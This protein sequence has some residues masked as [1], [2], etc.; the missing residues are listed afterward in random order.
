MR[1]S[2][3]CCNEHNSKPKYSQTRASFQREFYAGGC[4]S[5]PRTRTG[6]NSRKLVENASKTPNYLPN[7]KVTCRNEFSCQKNAPKLLAKTRV[8]FF[9]KTHLARTGGCESPKILS[10]CNCDPVANHLSQTQEPSARVRVLH[11]W[12]GYHVILWKSCGFH[13]KSM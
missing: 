9:S 12:L 13:R 7:G 3:H 2:S 11:F 6:F 1:S 4:K 5:H 8:R 10:C